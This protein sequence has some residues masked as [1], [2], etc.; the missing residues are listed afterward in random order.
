MLSPSPMPT[1]A[2]SHSGVLRTRALPNWAT[3]PSVILNTPP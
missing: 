2:D 1:M 3:K